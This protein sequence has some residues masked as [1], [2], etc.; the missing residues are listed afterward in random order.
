MER[1]LVPVFILE[2][3][4]V[5][6]FPDVLFEKPVAVHNVQSSSHFSST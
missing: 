3:R 5:F 1:F 2:D 4:N 6:C